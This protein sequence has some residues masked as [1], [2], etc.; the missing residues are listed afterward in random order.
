MSER[1]PGRRRADGPGSQPVG[2]LAVRVIADGRLT[3]TAV[4]GV[5]LALALIVQVAGGGATQVGATVD[6]V[7]TAELA[8]P[9]TP[10]VGA[11]AD[12]LTVAAAPGQEVRGAMRVD[13]L[14]GAAKPKLRRTK[15]GVS[16]VDLSGTTAPAAVVRAT[17]GLAP[18]LAAERIVAIGEGP[19]RAL[20][21][22]T[23]LAAGASAW[24]VGAST[25]AGR[26][27]RLVLTN[28]EG[29]SASVGLRLWDEGGRVD[30]AGINELV[31][32]PRSTRVISLDGLAPDRRRL[33]VGVEVEVGQVSSALHLAEV[34]GRGADWLDPLIRPTRRLVVPGISAEAQD[35]KLFLL[36][37]GDRD[38]IVK[39]RVLGV[40]SDF[41]P[42]GADV[43]ELPAGTVREVDL[44]A[45]DPG[46]ALSVVV[47]SDAAV[48]AAVRTIAKVGAGPEQAW[49]GPAAA[50]TGP[51]SVPDG[52]AGAGTRTRLLLAAPDGDAAVRLVV[53]AGSAT[54]RTR[55]V[56]VAAGRTLVLDPG[57]RGS[58]SYTVVLEPVLDSGPVYVAR[59]LSIDA[60]GLTVS[61]LDTGRFSV[62]LP[63]VVPDLT[64]PTVARP[65]RS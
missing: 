30:V 47:S 65:G 13:E 46:R 56:K 7:R 10:A 6:E 51:T 42:A 4:A 14:S 21:S 32:E 50:L 44:N 16:G 15:P 54:P 35:R 12:R 33:G 43:V 8:C 37:P 61:S 24:F 23:C 27:S 28:I 31:V 64:A 18:G 52:R 36:A 40:D 53:Y 5:L 34:G 17:G 49:A 48:V 41:A 19:A 20:S 1:T 22:T 63:A 60:A 62:E 2:D 58:T 45:A 55:T 26:Q 9:T 11:G 59:V 3:A 39:V 38:A 29:T 25:T 57:P